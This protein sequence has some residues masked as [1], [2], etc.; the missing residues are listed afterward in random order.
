MGTRSL[1]HFYAGEL[2]GT[3]ILT[4]YRQYDGYP[5]GTGAVSG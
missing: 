1:I 3:P 4:V 5:D 2:T